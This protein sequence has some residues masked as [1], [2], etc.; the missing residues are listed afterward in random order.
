MEVSVSTAI[1]GF[2]IFVI[3]VATVIFAQT[4]DGMTS[5]TVGMILVLIC[6]LIKQGVDLAVLDRNLVA[7]D[8]LYTNMT[9]NTL[10]EINEKTAAALATANANATNANANA[11]NANATATTKA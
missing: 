10:S 1:T 6:L 9:I 4:G 8:R 7:F 11:T 5:V 3:V 2:A